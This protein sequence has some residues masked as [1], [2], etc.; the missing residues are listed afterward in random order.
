LTERGPFILLPEQCGREQRHLVGGKASSLGELVRAGAKV[1]PFFALSSEAYSDF[2]DYNS[3]RPLIDRIGK[4]RGLEEV[5][6]L[7]EEI[8]SSMLSGS[9]PQRLERELLS[10]FSE[11]RSRWGSVAVRSSA[12]REDASAASFAGQFET[13]L[14]VRGDDELLQ[15]VMGC[16]ASLYNDRAVTYRYRMG[17]PQDDVQMAIVVQ[18]LVK[19]RSAGVIFTVN[20][21]NGDPSVIAIESSWGLGEAVVKGEVIPDRYLINKVT[22]EVLR[23]DVSPS[24]H[25]R[26]VPLDDG[27]VI[28]VETY[29]RSGE[30]S[31][32]RE[33]ALELAKM[34]RSLEAH[35]GQPQDVEWVVG[36]GSGG[37]GDVFVVQS[38][39]VTVATTV[40]R[41]SWQSS[42]ED[43]LER[44]L[45]TLMKGVKV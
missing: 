3:I 43:P 20:P 36:A 22:L 41:P 21:V 25:V 40:T 24:K 37:E 42:I 35:F 12:T 38:R 19:A 23:F 11:L 9:F 30:L 5:L 39:P 32:E 8:R 14:G 34:G 29:E 16:Y 27:R 7:A 45:A 2:I 15:S 17:L 4:A 1:P 13:Y 26:Y 33:E 6:R 10:V 18:G 28:R 44:V 31:L